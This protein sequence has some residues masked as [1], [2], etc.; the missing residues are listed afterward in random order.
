MAYASKNTIVATFPN[1]ASA[2]RA[3]VEL[4]N[5]G[6]R[7]SQI[8]LAGPDSDG[9]YTETGTRI[10]NPSDKLDPVIAAETGAVAGVSVGA[11]VG[12]GILVGVIPVIGPVVAAGTLAAILINAAEVSAI[13]GLTGALIGMGVSEAEAHHL[14]GEVKSGK[15]IITVQGEGRGDEVAEILFR[16][17]GHDRQNEMPELHDKINEVFEPT[18]H[19]Q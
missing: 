12:M 7:D 1:H 15:V 13:A 2:E 3:V 5:A 14:E 17:G 11:L 18:G 16:N 6:F 4:K 8:G 9:D 19:V 10:E